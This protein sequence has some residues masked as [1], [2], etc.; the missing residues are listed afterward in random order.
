MNQLN[1]N[2]L[3]YFWH[4]CRA[5]SITAAAEALSLTPQTITGQIKALA[6][7]AVPASGTGPGTD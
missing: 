2:H 3:Y 7:Q 4:A 6:G 5:G 1:F